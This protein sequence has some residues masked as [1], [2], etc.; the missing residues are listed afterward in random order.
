MSEFFKRMENEIALEKMGRGEGT[1]PISRI[2]SGVNLLTLVYLMVYLFKDQQY[3]PLGILLIL[4]FTRFG[5]WVSIGFLVYF[6]IT[7]YWIGT[8][9]VLLYGGIGWLSVWFGVRNIKRNLYSGRSTV[10]PFEGS[11]IL[12]PVFIFQLIFFALALLTSNILSAIFWALFGLVI[13]Y[14]TGF[15]YHRLRAPWCRLHFPLMV[16]YAGI[17]GYK[18]AEAKSTAKDFH[19]KEALSTL[20]KSAYPYMKDDEVDSLIGSAEKKMANFSDR[21]AL[22]E[23]FM[24]G[25]SSIDCNKLQELMDKIEIALK[26]QEEKGLYIRYVIAEIIG[27]DYGEQER[28]KY[29]HSVITGQAH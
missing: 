20:V 27:R 23:L 9:L 28:Q 16:R 25:K 22:N 4:G 2:L 29:I 10:D 18:V 6:I 7:K 24:K 21:E 8:A 1:G 13:L 15:F 11:P 26:N 5:H 3:V 12:L 14:E 17:A 19:I